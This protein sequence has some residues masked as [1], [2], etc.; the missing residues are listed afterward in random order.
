MGFI[1]LVKNKAK[2]HYLALASALIVGLLYIGPQLVF[3]HS[4]GNKYQGI[5]MLQTP[6]EDT[7]LARIHEIIDGHPL[8]GSFPYYE[9]KDQWPISP[10][11]GEMFYALPTLLFG[12]PLVT[13]LI[14]SKFILPLILF[15]LI[16]A[17]TYNLLP[18][19]RLFSRKISA[20]SAALL[21]LLGYDLV[22]YRSLLGFFLRGEPLGGSFLLWA[23]PVNPILGAIFLLAFLLGVWA[24]IQKTRYPKTAITSA[25]LSLSLMI[26]SYFF[27]WGIALSIL[28]F[29]ILIYFFKREYKIVKRFGFII[30]IAAILSSP[31]WYISYLSRQSPWYHDS[32]LRSGLIYT[33][34]PLLNKVLLAI[35]GL[36]LVLVF[37]PIIKKIINRVKINLQDWHWFCLALILGSSWAL[38]QQVVTG[39]TVWPYHF[40]QYT[41]PLS[42]VVLVVLL[43]R[44]ILNQFRFLWIF[45]I[46][47]IIGSSLLFG[48]YS[49]VHTYRNSYDYYYRMQSLAP[50]FAWFNRETKDCVILVSNKTE[51]YKLTEL[52]PAFTHC[53]MYVSYSVFSLMPNERIYHN[54]LVNLRLQG[55]SAENIEAYM[56][57]NETDMR[58]HLAS[59][60][61]GMLWTP[62]FPDFHD[63]TL[64]E[65][66]KKFPEGYK[67]FLN[68][69]FETELRKYKLDYVLSVGPL[70]DR[71]I[72]QLTSIKLAWQQADIYIYSI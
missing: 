46:I 23:R 41:I 53:N 8:V 7:Y 56:K 24:I 43:H 19:A 16:Y 22:D 36:Y 39:V 5:P 62:E 66:I 6:N 17:L 27:S 61:Q 26:M 60:W 40:V 44:I 12:I 34:Y 4:L 2:S 59:N 54:N 33:H 64:D 49:Q 45:A 47:S 50:V 30:A 31:Y 20:V 69:D 14:V 3:M 18:P 28:G 1:L 38:N 52:L 42:M 29:L 51:V 55:I 71:V 21:V 32:I 10:P 65:R 58:V 13:T 9:Y 70:T 72:K 37:I 63:Y 15:L 68:K 57:A 48:F 67:E 11:T 35:L 25:G